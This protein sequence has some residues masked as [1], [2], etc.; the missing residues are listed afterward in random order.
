MA[1]LSSLIVINVSCS[2]QIIEIPTAE[3]LE[4]I[5]TLP[6]RTRLRPPVVTPPPP[7]PE[8][9]IV[10]PVD[11]ITTKVEFV[12]EEITSENVV[13]SAGT[14]DQVDLVIVATEAPT[15][16][17]PVPPIEEDDIP[18]R[19]AEYMPS[20]PGCN[21]STEAER[22]SCTE[23]ALLQYVSKHLKYPTIARVNNVT[24]TVV[25]QFVIDRQGTMKDIKILRDIGAGCG[26]AANKIVQKLADTG[27][28]WQPGRQR[29]RAVSVI[30]T[31]PVRFQLE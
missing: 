1:V 27:G 23:R 9:S 5:E 31:L 8:K 4:D 17:A 11:N 18:H 21:G 22:R 3:Y 24:G 19:R 26:K 20:Y 28:D 13:D 25:V 29:G 10:T 14:N 7:L 6:P 15:W 16:P 2:R 12:P 30:Y